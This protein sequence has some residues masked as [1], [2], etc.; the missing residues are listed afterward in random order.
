MKYDSY[1]MKTNISKL[2]QLPGTEEDL[3]AEIQRQNQS[4]V[5]PQSEEEIIQFVLTRLA[6]VETEIERSLENG[7]ITEEEAEE[8]R[9]KYVRGFIRNLYR[10]ERT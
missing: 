6:M 9:N 2:I 5:L 3:E 7:E 1:R 10:D 8:L 4:G